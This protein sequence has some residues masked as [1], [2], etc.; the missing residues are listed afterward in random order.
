MSGTIYNCHNTTTITNYFV[1]KTISYNKDRRNLV[2]ISENAS[3]HAS[4]NHSATPINKS[5]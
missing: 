3:E 2:L 5:L 4:K 1:L